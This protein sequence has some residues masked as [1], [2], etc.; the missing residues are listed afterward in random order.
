MQV[1]VDVSTQDLVEMR[2]SP[3][4]LAEA[5][6]ATLGCLNVEGGPL[7]INDLDVEVSVNES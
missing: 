5:V 2:L 6:R 7:Y 1:R 3:E 4:E